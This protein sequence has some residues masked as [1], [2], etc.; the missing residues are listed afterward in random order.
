MLFRDIENP[1]DDMRLPVQATAYLTR[2]IHECMSLSIIKPVLIISAGISPNYLT[3]FHLPS[4]MDEGR[5]HKR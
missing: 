1:G 4:T 3:L 2:Y 5:V